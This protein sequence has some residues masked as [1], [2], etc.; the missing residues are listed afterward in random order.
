MGGEDKYLA[1]GPWRREW[2]KASGPWLTLV[3]AVEGAEPRRPVFSPPSCPEKRVSF[4][5]T[6]L[7]QAWSQAADLAPRLLIVLGG[8]V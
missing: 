7:G 5:S 8:P 4:L 1:Q 3:E 2:E 6:F